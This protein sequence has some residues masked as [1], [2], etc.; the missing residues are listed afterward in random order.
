MSGDNNGSINENVNTQDSSSLK[1]TRFSIYFN[2]QN[3][4]FFLHNVLVRHKILTLI[5]QLLLS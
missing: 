1:L 3:I 2:F 5:K 4:F